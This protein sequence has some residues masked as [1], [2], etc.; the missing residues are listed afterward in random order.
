[1]REHDTF[2][3]AYYQD[4]QARIFRNIYITGNES[5]NYFTKEIFNLEDQLKLNCVYEDKVIVLP[6]LTNFG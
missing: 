6:I 4:W 2:Q 3:D 1:M 5:Y